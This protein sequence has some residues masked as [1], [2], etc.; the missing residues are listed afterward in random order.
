LR[1]VMVADHSRPNSPV[2]FTARISAIGAY[3]VK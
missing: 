3:K 2:G 1:L